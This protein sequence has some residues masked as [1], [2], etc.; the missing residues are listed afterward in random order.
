MLYLANPST[1]RVRDAMRA[2][3]LGFIDTPAQGN[4]PIPGVPVAFDNGCFGKGWPGESAWF[5]WLQRNAYRAPDAL[6][7]VAPDVVGDAA[8]TLDRSTPWLSRIRALGYPAAFVAQNGAERAGIPWDDIDVLF[9]GG[10]AECLSCQWVR[11]V[12]DRDTE[13]CPGCYRQLREWKLGTVARTLAAE[14]HARGKRLHMG[15]VNSGRRFRYAKSIGCQT[16]DGTTLAMYPDATLPDVLS[17]SSEPLIP[18]LFE[19][20]A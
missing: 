10:S 16:A 2:G 3:L 6:F 4:V 9:L 17:W 12:E 11:P 7:G 8:A 13:F 19:G 14:A 20:A 18:D 1:E 5:G 15:R